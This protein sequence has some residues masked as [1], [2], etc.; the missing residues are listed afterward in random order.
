MIAIPLRSDAST[1]SIPWG[2]VALIL[3]NVAVHLIWTFPREQVVI[4]YMIDYATISPMQWLTSAFLHDG[5]VH[6]IGNMVF[7][8]VFGV[9]VEAI[10]GRRF[11]PL[12]IVLCLLSGALEQILLNALG[13]QGHSLGASSA[14]FGLLTLGL[15]W[16]PE[17][18]ITL[19][20]WLGFWGFK[21][22][23]QHVRLRWV[24]L[25]YLGWELLFVIIWPQE[26]T[27]SLLHTFGIVTAVP[28]G[29]LMLRWRMVNCGNLDLLSLWRNRNRP[30]AEI[31]GTSQPATATIT[32]TTT[33]T[34]A[35]PKAAPSLDTAIAA[36]NEAVLRQDAR[37]IL[38]HLRTVLDHPSRWTAPPELYDDVIAVLWKAGDEHHALHLAQERLAAHP[39]HG[40]WCRLI[41]GTALLTTEDN[42]QGALAQLTR[43]RPDNLAPADRQEF[44]RIVT[45][46][47][48]RLRTARFTRRS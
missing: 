26:I 41:A 2:T 47:E 12:Y 16:S 29:L 22:S 42:P 19:L 4:P 9:V 48:Q 34:P 32:A 7:L 27:S 24:A 6:L 15:L 38:A 18:R 11:I 39:E 3:F 44:Q 13:Q 10:L 23:I 35:A 36:L 1:E 40:D 37:G 45:R 31:L 8:G 30:V 43:I 28:I 5:W 14:L 17:T 21:P 33:A 25:W 46:A 20:V